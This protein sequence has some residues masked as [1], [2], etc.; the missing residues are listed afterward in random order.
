[1]VARSMTKGGAKRMTF[2]CVS[3]ARMERSFRDFAAPRTPNTDPIIL[4]VGGFAHPPNQEAVLWFVERILPLIRQRIPAVKLTIVGSNPP[5]KLL[6]LADGEI[7]VN[8]N[9][10]DTDLREH[11]SRARVA[12][13]PLRYGAGV[14]LKV[15]E[16]LREGLPLVTTPVGAQ[17]LPGLDRVASV[18][19][20]MRSFA[21]AVCELLID[22]RLWRER[23]AAQID[24]AASR[25]SEEAFR[26]RLLDAMAI[27]QSPSRCATRCIS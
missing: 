23:S 27:V 19:D 24:Y 13:V 22:D 16:A 21:D 8:A 25:Y 17:G 15:V 14:K 10:S 2:S 12:V 7:T 5:Q 1:M 6:G 4:F 20:D 3:L 26:T 9:V 18:R 11:Y